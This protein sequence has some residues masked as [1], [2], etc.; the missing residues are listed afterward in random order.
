VVISDGG[1]I[2]GGDACALSAVK[3]FSVLYST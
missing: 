2:G 1:D 3:R